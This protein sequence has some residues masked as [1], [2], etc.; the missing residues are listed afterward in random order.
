MDALQNSFAK[1]TACSHGKRSILSARVREQSANKERTIVCSSV[2]FPRGVDGR[3]ACCRLLFAQTPAPHTPP[4]LPPGAGE[5][6]SLVAFHV[7]IARVRP[8]GTYDVNRPQRE[9][10][11]LNWAGEPIRD[12]EGY[13]GRPENIPETWSRKLAKAAAEQQ[14]CAITE[15]D[16]CK[17]FGNGAYTL[18]RAEAAKLLELITRAHRTTCYRAL[19]LD[20]R[21]GRHL[22][23]NG[24][25]LSWK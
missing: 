2:R 21:F 10:P 1:L 24:K 9:P 18:T 20:G 7:H 19:E 23:V 17:V 11:E 16:V 6:P 8:K 12:G 5:V 14:H 4:P 15:K 3:T 22:H 13:G 25:W